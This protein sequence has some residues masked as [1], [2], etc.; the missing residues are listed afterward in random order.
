M[1]EEGEPMIV[2]CCRFC[3]IPVMPDRVKLGVCDST[4]CVRLLAESRSS[5]PA[6]QLSADEFKARLRLQGGKP[7]GGYR[8]KGS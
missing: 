1:K 5:V 7:A 6:K 4:E 2:F 8:G 3:G